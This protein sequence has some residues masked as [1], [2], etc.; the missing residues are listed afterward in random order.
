LLRTDAIGLR[1]ASGAGI[2]GSHIAWG[3]WILIARFRTEADP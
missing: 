1:D 3:Q 2:V